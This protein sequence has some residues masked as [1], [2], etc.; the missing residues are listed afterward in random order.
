MKIKWWWLHEKKNSIKNMIFILN[1][2]LQ[3]KKK[4]KEFEQIFSLKF[5]K[6]K[7]ILLCKINVVEILSFF[8]FQ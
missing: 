7:T 4:K 8:V 5:K 2:Y 3:K 6:P 1:P